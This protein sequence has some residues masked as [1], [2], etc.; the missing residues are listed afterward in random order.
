[1]PIT[2]VT[3]RYANALADVVTAAGAGLD[4]QAAAAELSG[5]AQ[6]VAESAELRNALSMP[7]VAP[8]RKRAVVE[9]I[10]AELGISRI[11]RNLLFV[12]V[13]HRR[14][15]MLTDLTA[16]FE[17]VMDERLGFARAE[18]A[19]G[20]ELTPAQ[21]AAI[22]VELERVT[23]KRIRGRFGVD[24]ALIGG[25]TARIGSTVYDG[26]VRAQLVAIGRSLSAEGES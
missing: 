1:M 5:F 9:R 19:A 23:G 10:G 12:L 22:G 8:S 26:S 21:Q 13:D 20:L 11:V 14:I 7:A 18:V 25:V 24:P 2:A 15:A 3:S 4:P 16:A 6:V 17:A